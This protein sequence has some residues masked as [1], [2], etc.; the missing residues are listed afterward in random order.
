MTLPSGVRSLKFSEY[1]DCLKK[2]ESSENLPIFSKILLK[3]R[4]S[5]F[6]RSLKILKILKFFEV[7]SRFPQ[8][9]T[10]QKPHAD[11]KTPPLVSQDKQ[12]SPP[13]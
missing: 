6:Q 10:K 1:L 13:R 11:P 4:L 12:K 3:I 7:F 8:T 2:P 5:I 9:S